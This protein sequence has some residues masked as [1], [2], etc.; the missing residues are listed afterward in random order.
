MGIVT[1]V[2][3]GEVLGMLPDSH[4]QK[5]RVGGT[6]AL[7]VKLLARPGVDTAGVLGSGAQAEAALECTAAVAPLKRVKIFSPTRENRERYARTMSE[8][9][10]ISV[11]AVD[12]PEKVFDG[13]GI[14]LAATSS[15]EPVYRREWLQPGL[16]LGIDFSG[17]II[18]EV[19]TPGTADFNAIRSSLLDAQI[20]VQG[21]QRF[22]DDAQVVV[23]QV[24]PLV[25]VEG[26]EQLGR[27]RDLEAEREGG[28]G[29]GRQRG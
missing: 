24:E 29:G 5:M 16:H 18:M 9:L 4:I 13:A 20:P 11:T 3:T 14:V 25:Q 21:V 1:D 27:I 2:Q 12:T 26:A 7:G 10:G 28:H 22:G 19:R 23:Q 17:G 6:T 15:Y 8:R